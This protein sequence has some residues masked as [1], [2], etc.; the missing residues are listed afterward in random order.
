MPALPLYA[1][2]SN[3][4]LSSLHLQEKAVS[5]PV[6]MLP[7]REPVH[8]HHFLNRRSAELPPY[9]PTGLC[10]P[11]MPSRNMSVG[12]G[13]LNRGKCPCIR[14]LG[15]KTEPRL[16]AAKAELPRQ[17]FISPVLFPALQSRAV[18]RRNSPC[19]FFT[20]DIYLKAQQ[21]H[22]HKQLPHFDGFPHKLWIS[23]CKKCNY[24]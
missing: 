21:A 8:L 7:Y 2:P 6:L 12:T 3:F 14:T 17:G 13:A 22:T 15:M 18:C 1:R 24:I 4:G 5:P 23:V 16:T 9:G 20:W 19:S 11:H 10:H